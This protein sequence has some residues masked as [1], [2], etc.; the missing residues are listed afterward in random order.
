MVK[1][2]TF[3]EAVARSG[4]KRPHVLLGNGFSRS[5]KNDIFAYD[6]L[7]DRAEFAALPLAKGAFSAL[8]TT[9]FEVVIRALQSSA[10]II[11]AYR[12]SDGQ[13]AK[14]MEDFAAGLR[15]LLVS[16]I[17]ASHPEYPAQIPDAA[18][19]GCREFLAN[20]EKIYSVNYD[21]LL[22]WA[23]MHDDVE[24]KIS[25]D[26]GFRNPD[27]PDTD[28]VTWEVE[29]SNKQNVFYVH[30]ALHIFDSGNEL[31]K[32]T[33]NRTGVRLIDQIRSA[34][35]N[36][37]YPVFVAEGESAQKKA[38]IRHSEILFRAYR[39]FGQIGG[40]LFT[41]G[42]SFAPNDEHILRLME[43]GKFQKLFVSLYGDPSSVDNL[44]SIRRVEEM[45][46]RRSQRHPL[47]IHFYDA[48]SAHVW[49]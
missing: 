44:K 40:C 24:P 36:D 5:I 43:K 34:V 12:P 25:C 30:G 42:L 4:S 27:E 31:K 39:S 13:L 14:A 20:F 35:E 28:Y 45:P 21:L 26:D 47:D 32:Y 33:W 9:D 15:E 3:A 7:F 38:R 41:Y 37:F 19:A 16:T 18:Y 46:S 29:N 8:A 10:A 11:R 17:A 49:G 6:A 22:Y 1:L 48:S 2:I 23:L